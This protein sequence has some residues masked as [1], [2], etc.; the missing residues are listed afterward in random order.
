MDHVSFYIISLH[1]TQF[2]SNLPAIFLVIVFLESNSIREVGSWVEL[3][4]SGFFKY[5]CFPGSSLIIKDTMIVIGHTFLYFIISSYQQF[6][7]KT[8]T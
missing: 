4:L 1:I 8:I 3:C 7:T 5:N 6:S 2:I